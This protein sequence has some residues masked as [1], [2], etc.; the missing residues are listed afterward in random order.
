MR[1]CNRLRHGVRWIAARSLEAWLA[2]TRF[3]ESQAEIAWAALGV[4]ALALLGGVTMLAGA[5]LKS[6][7]GQQGAP[8]L[9]YGIVLISLAGIIALS[10][11]GG[12]MLTIWSSQKKDRMEKTLER[13]SVEQERALL[14]QSSL[15]A[16]NRRSRNASRL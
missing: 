7:G 2:L 1:A 10:M 14:D 6:L 4:A 12:L 9:R 8:E 11:V 13:L 5:G 15:K 16:K 3:M